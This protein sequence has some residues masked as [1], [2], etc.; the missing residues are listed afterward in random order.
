MANGLELLEA[1]IEQ[2]NDAVEAFVAD[3]EKIKKAIDKGSV[4]G[5]SPVKL[6]NDSF[7]RFTLLNQPLKVEG[8]DK[9]LD[10][11]SKL[12]SAAYDE[13]DTDFRSVIE[14]TY[15]GGASGSEGQPKRRG[16][17]PKDQVQSRK[18]VDL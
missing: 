18:S 8:K 14:N 17:K 16:R 7:Y 13:K 12:I 1:H 9:A 6:E 11:V 4:K 15:G 3:A 5:R 2:K 10:L